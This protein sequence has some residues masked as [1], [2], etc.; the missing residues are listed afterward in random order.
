MSCSDLAKLC[1]KYEPLLLKTYFTNRFMQ[2]K[3]Y[4]GKVFLCFVCLTGDSFTSNWQ[5]NCNKNYEGR[6]IRRNERYEG[7]RILSSLNSML[8]H[9]SRHHPTINKLTSFVDVT[10]FMDH[11]NWCK[12]H[13]MF[14]EKKKKR[15]EQSSKILTKMSHQDEFD[16]ITQPIKLLPSLPVFRMPNKLPKL[17][18]NWYDKQLNTAHAREY[19]VKPCAIPDPNSPDNDRV[20]WEDKIKKQRTVL[21]TNFQSLNSTEPMHLSF[22][23]FVEKL[24]SFGDYG[25][26]WP[27]DSL[28]YSDWDEVQW[29]NGNF[30]RHGKLFVWPCVGA[31]AVEN[32]L[33]W[34][35]NHSAENEISSDTKFISV[36]DNDCFLHYSEDEIINEAKVQAEKKRKLA[37]YEKHCLK[38]SWLK[39]FLSSLVTKFSDLDMYDMND[40][41]DCAEMF[42]AV[43]KSVKLQTSGINCELKHINH[44]TFHYV[45]LVK[46]KKEMTKIK[47]S[48]TCL[49][50]E[51]TKARKC[52]FFC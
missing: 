8:R 15:E 3:K 19:F 51:V 37:E 39:S 35:Y 52:L 42:N 7:L 33:D 31:T 17:K 32:S 44:D 36:D 29:K 22:E 5:F 41:V 46:S 11:T 40:D 24:P 50:S 4:D 18:R 12:T 48:L 2:N 26:Y 20:V 49:R 45:L 38:I 13:Q 6:Y 10:N 21:Q 43:C 47:T 34:L 25:K 30:V 27:D 28:N 1:S 16:S 9:S 23:T 14:C